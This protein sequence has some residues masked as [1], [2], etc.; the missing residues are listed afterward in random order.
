MPGIYLI[1]EGHGEER[2]APKLFANILSNHL[3]RKDF[4]FWPAFRVSRGGIATTN[5]EMRMALATARATIARQQGNGVL[6]VLLDADD[7][8]AVALADGIGTAINNGRFPFTYSVVV[9]VREYEAWFLASAQSL[10]G[11]PNVRI[12]AQ[13]SPHPERPRD[14]K[15][16][17]QATILKPG[18]VY[19]PTVDQPEFSSHLD[20]T[21]ALTSRSFRKL[22]RELDQA[23]P[24]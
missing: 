12:D 2:A 3:M 18:A 1:V 24:T 11:L 23:I 8:C 9:C 5:D 22:V 7:D 10:V 13:N 14:A 15:G 20:V 19:S 6:F 16:A 17:V 4:F 21:Q